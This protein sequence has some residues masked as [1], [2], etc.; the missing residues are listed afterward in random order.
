M[1]FRNVQEIEMESKIFAEK[2]RD[3]SGG[4]STVEV[5]MGMGYGFGDSAGE[6]EEP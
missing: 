2:V 4:V 1:V 6:G 3:K 5:A